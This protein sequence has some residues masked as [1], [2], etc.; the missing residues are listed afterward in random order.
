ME[1][2][3]DE[4]EWAEALPT[5]ATHYPFLLVPECE[6]ADGLYLLE[7][8][9]AEREPT[10]NVTC[11]EW[12]EAPDDEDDE[13]EEAFKT[14]ITFGLLNRPIDSFLEDTNQRLTRSMPGLRGIDRISLSSKIS[15]VSDMGDDDPH[16]LCEEALEEAVRIIGMRSARI[17]ERTPE[18]DSPT[19]LHELRA[20]WFAVCADLMGPIPL[21]LPPLREINH[22]INLIDEKA[23]YNYHLPRCPEALRP[24]LRAKIQRYTDAGWWEMTSVSQ[25][26]PLLCIPKKDYKLRTVVD[27]RQRND[28]TVKDVTPVS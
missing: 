5:L 2:V 3:E 25:A 13:D 7:A 18:D 8:A 27:A 14:T 23:V 26:A 6:F 21:E 12:R 4:D 15:Q 22:E 16:G 28:N 9:I 17:T 24:E 1:E 10:T 20:K 19:R 11:D